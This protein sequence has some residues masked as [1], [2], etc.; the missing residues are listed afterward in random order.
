MDGRRRDP[1]VRAVAYE[2]SAYQESREISLVASSLSQSA[3]YKG[4]WDTKTTRRVV[5]LTR[6]QAL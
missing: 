6:T 4:Y 1:A 3:N 2:P 5:Y